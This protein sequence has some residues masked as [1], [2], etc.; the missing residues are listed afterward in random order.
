MSN[1]EIGTPELV[2][3]LQMLINDARSIPLSNKLLIDRDVILGLAQ[4]LADSVPADV[5]KAAQI[6]EKENEIIDVSQKQANEK[7]RDAQQTAQTTIDNAKRDAET[8]K[9]NAEANAAETIRLAHEQAD[10][11]LSSAH[12]EGN[13]ILQD[14]QNRASQMVSEHEI[15][16]RARAEAQE[17][18][19]ATQQECD[20]YSRRVHEA[21]DGMME[22]ADNAM[23]RQLEDIRTLRQQMSS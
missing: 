2:D 19:D 11:I 13:R 16:T 20:D 3:R 15:V 21:L 8:V 10:A 6:V 9:H 14:A 7:I 23:T 18:R 4:K 22:Q 17:L 1:N 5:K 12:S